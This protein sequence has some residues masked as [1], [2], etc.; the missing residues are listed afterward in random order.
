MKPFKQ[1][2]EEQFELSEDVAA[3]NVA[4]SGAQHIAKYDPIMRFK[5]FRGKPRRTK[6]GK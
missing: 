6:Q 5:M 1:Y 2:L 3:N 4:H